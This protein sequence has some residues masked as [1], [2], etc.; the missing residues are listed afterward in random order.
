VPDTADTCIAT[1]IT[2]RGN[3][4]RKRRRRRKIKYIKEEDDDEEE[5]ERR[6]KHAPYVN[7]LPCRSSTAE[8]REREEEETVPARG[9]WASSLSAW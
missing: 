3:W 9:R 6:K 4:R 5:D 2:V 8:Q 7:I 1:T